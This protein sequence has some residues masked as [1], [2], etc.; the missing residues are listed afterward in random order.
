MLEFCV[1]ARVSHGELVGNNLPPL[2]PTAI[3]FRTHYSRPWFFRLPPSHRRSLVGICARVGHGGPL[4]NNIPL[5]PTAA[6]FRK[7]NT[8]TVLVRPW[9]FRL[10]P[11]HRRSPV[12]IGARVGLEGPVASGRFCPNTQSVGARYMMSDDGYRQRMSTIVDRCQL[13]VSREHTSCRAMSTSS[14]GLYD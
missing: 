11:S 1:C 4:G 6:S 13:H 7:H 12:G 9:F 2:A 14:V 3:C 10:P 8:D 5:A